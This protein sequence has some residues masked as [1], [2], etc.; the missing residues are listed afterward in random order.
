M[1]DDDDGKGVP[2]GDAHREE[3]ITMKSFVITSHGRLLE[4][5][6]PLSEA[7]WSNM[8]DDCEKIVPFGDAHRERNDNCALS[9]KMQK[10]M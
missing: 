10:L 5:V 7:L 3:R 6:G 8:D 1:E 4:T 9:V 2:F